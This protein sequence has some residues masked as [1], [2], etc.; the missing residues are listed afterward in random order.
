MIS[1]ARDERVIYEIRRHWYVLL[2]ESF[3]LL[4]FFF[5]P[6]AVF[7]GIDV[8]GVSLSHDEG[9]V[10]IFLS[11]LW[12]FFTWLAFMV[13]WTN[14]YLDVWIVTNRRIID[15]EQHGLFS[16]DLSEFRLDRIQ[17]ITIEVKGFLPTILHF[18]DIHVQTAG[19]TREFV[20]HSIP[21][22]YKV[23]DILVKE[24]DRA[25]AESHGQVGH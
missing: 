10:F 14:Y 8:A 2:I 13:I 22:P 1:L 17:D 25:V 9:L 21:K 5:I 18:G 20:I 15:I 3:F 23:R 7:F 19:E 12:L 4:L 16:R 6:W 11:L 24:H